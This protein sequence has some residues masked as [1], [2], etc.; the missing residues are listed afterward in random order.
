MSNANGRSHSNGFAVGQTTE[1][2]DKFAPPCNLE[3]E[4]SVLGSVLLDDSMLPAVSE[5]VCVADFYR[6]AHQVV[7]QAMLDLYELGKPI[8]AVTLADELVRQDMFHKIGGDDLL[9]DIVGAVPHAANALYYAQI[10]KELADKR[11]L[12]EGAQDIA[13]LIRDRQHTSSQLMDIATRKIIGLGIDVD[14]EENRLQPLPARMEAGAFSGLA[15]EIIA[16]IEPHT[17]A[18]PAALLGQFLVA[19]GNMIGRRIYWLHDATRH[20]ANLFLTVVGSS[21]KSRKGTSWDIIRWLLATVDEE[22]NKERILSGLT[23]GEGLI[24]QVRDPIVKGDT[25]IDPGVIDKR[26]LFMEA[27]FGGML[28]LMG[29]EGSSLSAVV[30]TAFDGGYL[31]N[32]TKNSPQRA[33]GAH[34]SIIGHITAPELR[35]KLSEVDAWNGFSNRFLWL[36]ARRSKLLPDGGQFHRI[37]F[38]GV[39]KQLKNVYGF[40]KNHLDREVLFERDAHAAELW[41]QVYGELTEARPGVFGAVI[42]RAECLI[43]RLAMIYAVLDLQ[44]YIRRSHLESALA[45][46]RHCQATASFLFGDRPV[47]QAS[48]KVLAVIRAHQEGVGRDRIK[49]EA[50]GGRKTDEL[51]QIL[52]V[53]LSAGLVGFEEVVRN[54]KKFTLWKAM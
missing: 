38:T 20:H 46:W 27:E 47:D 24:A 17:E 26:A 13:A 41:H 11:R 44:V 33:T 51:D 7:Y 19:F 4:R 37:D 52:A 6:D 25:I 48:A 29:R 8:D 5:I 15:G 21:S 54:R 49:R 18:D 42:S 10:V 1:G 35:D 14:E 53:L 28:S 36:F 31:R 3:A 12:L 23:T 39:F 9:S 22:W 32:P 30:R 43:M 34:V 45:F 16:L 50:F 40:V 2:F